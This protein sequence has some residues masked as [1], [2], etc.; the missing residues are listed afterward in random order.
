[1]KIQKSQ[2]NHTWSQKNK[3][4]KKTEISW[5]NIKRNSKRKL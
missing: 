1:M 5:E 4:I 3:L 2:G